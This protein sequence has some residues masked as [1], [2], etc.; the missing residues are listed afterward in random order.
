M[1]WRCVFRRHRWRALEGSVGQDIGWFASLSQVCLRCG[2]KRFLTSS[3]SLT[4]SFNTEEQARTWLHAHG[5]N[6][7]ADRA[8]R[9]TG[10]V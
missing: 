8:I 7:A 3:T 10:D 4:H 9:T 6:H 5:W 2:K 1:S